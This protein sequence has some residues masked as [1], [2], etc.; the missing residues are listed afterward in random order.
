VPSDH[1]ADPRRPVAVNAGL[2][3]EAVV[4]VARL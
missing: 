2:C 1:A 4:G 3:D